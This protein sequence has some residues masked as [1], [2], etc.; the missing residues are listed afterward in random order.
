MVRNTTRLGLGY[1]QSWGLAPTLGVALSLGAALGLAEGCA[2]GAGDGPGGGGPGGG[3]DGGE[4]LG[5][6]DPNSTPDGLCDERAKSIYLVSRQGEGNPAKLV[7]F[8]PASKTFTEVG[9]IVCEGETTQPYSMG[10]RRDGT[11]EM[12]FASGHIHYVS[13]LDAS[14]TPSAWPTTGVN[15]YKLFGMGYASDEAGGDTET[16][17][18]GASPDTKET[19]AILMARLAKANVQAAEATPLATSFPSYT[20]ELTGNGKGELWGFRPAYTYYRPPPAAGTPDGPH[21]AAVFRFNKADGSVAE[22]FELPSLPDFSAF[23]FAHWG[24][25]YY[26]F[27]GSNGGSTNVWEFDPE[28]GGVVSY[29]PN[30]GLNVVGAGVST[31]APVVPVL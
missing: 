7:R 5:D 29:V 2:T 28:T 27:L 16:L 20:P 9:E 24:G 17:F 11:A 23:A 8:E 1:G 19:D 30:T 3:P 6:A 12:V 25:R 26:I 21:P 14:C 31:C 18:L 13:T 15:N 22:K 10:V 4:W